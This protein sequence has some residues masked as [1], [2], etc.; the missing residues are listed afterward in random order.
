MAG[1]IIEVTI[2][3]VLGPH[4]VD[5]FYTYESESGR[6]S[7]I[8]NKFT[9][10]ENNRIAIMNPCMDCSIELTPMVCNSILNITSK[11]FS[12]EIS[13]TFTMTG[14]NTSQMRHQTSQT[15]EICI[16]SLIGLSTIGSAI[17]TTLVAI[18]IV[19]GC[20]LK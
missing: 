6:I 18:I 19:L 3:P 12:V 1:G 11:K 14:A 16:G 9:L 2:P 13:S 20:K 15:C 5:Y 4:V 10:T 8:C 7:D 17:I